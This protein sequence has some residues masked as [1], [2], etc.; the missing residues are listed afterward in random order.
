MTEPPP[1]GL[2]AG[3][4]G[5][6]AAALLK[7]WNASSILANA[8]VFGTA[9]ETASAEGNGGFLD[10]RRGLTPSILEKILAR[11]PFFFGG[12]K[13]SFDAIKHHFTPSDFDAKRKPML[14]FW[15]AIGLLESPPKATSL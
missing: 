9:G 15:I 4:R 3:G 2:G 11:E 8:S 6:G 14:V 12:T 10:G 5:V 1:T 7:I 13:K